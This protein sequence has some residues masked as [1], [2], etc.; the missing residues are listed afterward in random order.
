MNCSNVQRRLLAQAEP[1]EPS[2]ALQ[3]HLETCPLCQEWQRRLTQIDRHV[4]MLP[5]PR[6]SARAEFVQRFR[7]QATIWEKARYRLRNLQRWQLTAGALAASILLFILAWTLAPNDPSPV[8]RANPTQ[9]PHYNRG[10][11]ASSR[12]P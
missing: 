6:S 5:V 8:A 2:D 1:A 11:M 12:P 3:A 7:G 9:P 4:P 10:R